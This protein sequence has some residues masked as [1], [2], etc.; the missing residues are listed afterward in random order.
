M[1]SDTWM[2]NVVGL[3]SRQFMDKLVKFRMKNVFDGALTPTNVDVFQTNQE[4]SISELV[5][6]RGWDTWI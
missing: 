3:L 4:N 1:K 6:N 5:M 2:E